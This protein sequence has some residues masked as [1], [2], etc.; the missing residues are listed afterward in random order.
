MLLRNAFLT[1][2]IVCGVGLPAGQAPSSAA[3]RYEVRRVVVGTATEHRCLFGQHHFLTILDDRGSLVLR[4]RPGLD[5]NG[6]GSSLHLQPFLAGAVLSHTAVVR[7]EATGQGI[8]FNA[9]GAVSRGADS[10]YGDWDAQLQFQYDPT[11]KSLRGSGR[12]CVTLEG[13]LA[14][15]GAGA[16]DLSLLKIASN[17]L[18]D[19]P[20]HG[21]GRGDTGDMRDAIVTGEGLKIQWHPPAQPALA[22]QDPTDTLSITVSGQFNN[23]DSSALRQ[24]P[25]APAYKPSLHVTLTSKQ[26]GATMLVAAKYD[27]SKAQLF[28]EDNVG[29]TP[30][31]PRSSPLA[32]FTFDLLVSSQAPADDGK[33]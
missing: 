12:Y 30:L 24:P 19:V 32:R 11:G 25:I 14:A 4:P 29:I 28:W 22:P 31:V 16:G 13:P 17:Y 6:W 20:L 7:V 9:S 18:R 21:G 33:R 1:T 27:T 2:G 5:P 3:D 15:G 26:A 8:A 23:I 10:T